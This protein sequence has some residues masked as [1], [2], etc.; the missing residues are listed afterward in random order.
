MN[1]AGKLALIHADV[2]CLWR[3]RFCGVTLCLV[4]VLERKRLDKYEAYARPRRFEVDR[5]DFH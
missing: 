4:G 1:R 3:R 5:G 2:C